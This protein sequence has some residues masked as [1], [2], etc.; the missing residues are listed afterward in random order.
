MNLN[1]PAI[2]ELIMRNDEFVKYHPLVNFFYFTAVIAFSMIFR[3]PVCQLVSL[4]V[5]FAYGTYLKG[6]EHI[7]FNFKYILVIGILTAVINPVFNHGGI[8]ILTYLPSGNPLTLESIL[9]GVSSALMLI[10]VVNWFICMNTV[11]TSDKFMYLFGKIIP[12]LSLV[13]SMTLRFI[14]RFSEQ[15]KKIVYAQKCMGRGI[16][17]GSIYQRIKNAVNIMS[18]LI[19]WALETGVETADSMRSRGFGLKGRTAFTPYK[20]EKRDALLLAFMT[21]C[22]AFII[23]AAVTGVLNFSYFPAVYYEFDGCFISAILIYG[24]LCVVPLIINL[25]EDIKW[26][27]LSNSK[28]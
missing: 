14:P 28:M 25:W 11:F 10:S 13:L 7:K 1:T 20:L 22:I 17:N 19:T 6:T 23:A 21:V 26:K 27:R 18:I 15:F 3:N 8:T 2:T 5:S 12:S 9:F 24:G 4:A 16:N